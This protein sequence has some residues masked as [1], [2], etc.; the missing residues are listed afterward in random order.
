MRF[1]RKDIN[2]K[3]LENVNPKQVILSIGCGNA[4]LEKEI[5]KLGSIVYGIDVDPQ[6]ILIAKDKIDEAITLDIEK[7]KELPY[8]QKKFDVIIFIDVLEHL[9]DPLS[10]LKKVKPYLKR[11]GYIIASIPNIANWRIRFG[12][13]FG[14][15]DYANYGILDRSHL[16]FYTLSN[17]KR[18][19]CEAGFNI[20]KV[21]FTT[22]MLNQ[23][24]ELS[25]E[26]FKKDSNSILNRSGNK[27]IETQR[28]LLRKLARFILENI[29]YM[30][31]KIFKGIFAFQFIL[32]AKETASS[33]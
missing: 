11:D 23:L 22:N 3:V 16:K 32:V 19:L 17:A 4:E 33:D 26:R 27:S 20:A 13:L 24:Y 21:D 9:L 5:K 14:K 8:T 18:L 15:F 1:V 7:T 2:Y 28:P 25:C 31:A 12:L 6:A 30:L 29:D 10:T